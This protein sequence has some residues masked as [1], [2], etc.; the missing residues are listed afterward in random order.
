MIFF[1]ESFSKNK[2]ARSF[3]MKCHRVKVW[4]TSPIL[5]T[6]IL[7]CFFFFC[8]SIY[9]KRIFLTE[10]DDQFFQF[11]HKKII[12]DVQYCFLW[13]GLFYFCLLCRLDFFFYFWRKDKLKNTYIFKSVE[14][15]RSRYQNPSITECC[16]FSLQ[17]MNFI[18]SFN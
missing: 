18:E 4:S 2:E 3:W 8:W 7:Q 10:N 9:Q 16:I 15:E 17:Y 14:R 12:G 1:L 13:L 6:T 5:I 11:H